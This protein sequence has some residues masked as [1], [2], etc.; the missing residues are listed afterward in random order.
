MESGLSVQKQVRQVNGKDGFVV[1]APEKNLLKRDNVWQHKYW[2]WQRIQRG[3]ND[4]LR[5]GTCANWAQVIA[6]CTL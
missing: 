4:V 1:K 2:R 5:G 6:S 3:R